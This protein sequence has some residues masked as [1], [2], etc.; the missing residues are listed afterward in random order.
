MKTRLIL[1]PILILVVA[2][3]MWFDWSLMGGDEVGRSLSE[4]AGLGA[5]PWGFLAL[6]TIFLAVCAHEVMKI[7][8]ACGMKSDRLSVAVSGF[9]VLASIVVFGP[10]SWGK[11]VDEQGLSAVLG[12]PLLAGLAFLLVMTGARNIWNR[13][14][15]QFPGVLAGSLATFMYVVVP[16][17]MLVAARLLVQVVP[18]DLVQMVMSGPGPRVVDP[19]LGLWLIVW[20]VVVVRLGADSCAYFVGKAMGKRKLIP[21]VSPGKTVEG[22]IGGLVGATLLGWGAYALMPG[23]SQV[24]TTVEVLVMGAAMGLVAPIGDLAA[25]ALKRGAGVK[26]SGKLLPEFGGSLDLIDG[27]LLAGPALYLVLLWKAASVG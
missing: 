16:G 25:S 9:A 23:L 3:A 24:F 22:F 5:R 12:T 2:L 6:A 26:D 13:D 14:V 19:H 20:L 10:V 7:F 17:A 1:G 8:D 15:K 18:A 21:H 11:G 4:F 27:F